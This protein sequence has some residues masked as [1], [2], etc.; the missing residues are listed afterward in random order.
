MTIIT[1]N[2]QLNVGITNVDKQHQK[3]VDILNQLD[4]AVAL[5]YKYK[6]I[7]QL[8]DELIDY[9]QYHFQEEEQLMQQSG[10]DAAQYK[11]HKLEHDEF[12]EKVTQE[13]TMAIDNPDTVSSVLLEFLVAWLMDHILYSDKQ[14]ALALS[15]APAINDIELRKQQADIMHSNLYLALRESE[16]RFKE[17]ADQLP[18]LI[19]ITNTQHI[20]IFCNRFWVEIFGLPKQK[21]TMDN[22]HSAID[23]DD[24]ELVKQAYQKASTELCEQQIEYR[25][26]RGEKGTFWMLEKI[27]P[28]IRANGHVAGLMGFGMDISLQKQAEAHLEILV[29][30]RTEQ[31]REVNQHLEDEKN[32]QVELNQQL[33]EV[34]SHLVQ[35]E[36]MASLGQLAAGV[37]HEINNPLGY[38]Y[39]NL[40]TLKQYIQDLLNIVESGQR[41]AAHL[42]ADDPAVVEFLRLQQS[43]DLDFMKDDIPDLVQEALEGATR[44]KKIVQDLRDFSRIDKQ[45]K[46]P[47]DLEAGIDATL[48]IVSNEIKYKAEVVKE[49]AGVKPFVCVGSQINQVILNLLVNA[50]QAIEEFGKIYIRTGYEPNWVWFEVEDTGKGIP[51]AIQSKIFD[52]FF[53]TKPVGKGTGLGLSLSYKII[54]DHQGKVDLQSAEGKG[55]KFRVSLPIP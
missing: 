34:Q 41:L 19:W 1:W 51:V 16:N 30:Q 31:L 15:R 26:N 25:L 29:D 50:A 12:I 46:S 13:R 55:T 3:L 43:A 42:P 10:Y 14:M 27:V 49:Y 9:T 47:F 21:I 24:I 28:R 37:A 23:P 40:N 8:V 39:S 44:A 7:L 22:W 33:K 45:D 4:E 53:T 11:K 38:I 32:Q 5:G 2:D 48:N 54:Q 20:P 6:K 17:L 35:S 18:A 36:K 52:P